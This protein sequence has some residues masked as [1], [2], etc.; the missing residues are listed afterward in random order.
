MAV[1]VLTNA[2]VT[3]NGVT[4]SDHVRKVTVNINS[5]EK[6]FTAMGATGKA[7]RAGLRDDSYTVEFNQDYAGGSVDATLFPLVGAAPF[8]V[9][10][11]ATTA[12]KSA[13]NPSYEGNAILT[14]YNP[15]DGQ[16]GDELVTEIE[17]P[18]DGVISRVTA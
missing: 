4:L 12:A 2:V 9:T 16:V 8:A 15:L 7:R 14:K 17:L 11:R 13:T 6:D 3:I 10:A 5:E 18:V 1:V